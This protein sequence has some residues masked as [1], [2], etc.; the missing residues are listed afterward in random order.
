MADKIY[1]TC[2]HCG[3]PITHPGRKKFCCTECR[4]AFDDHRKEYCA[5][6]GVKLTIENTYCRGY[7][8]DGKPW[9]DNYCKS[10]RIDRNSLI[11]LFPFV[12]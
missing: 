9:M 1:G 4:R 11:G 6:C 2:A 3:K 8:P 7:G 10:C 12:V 5:D